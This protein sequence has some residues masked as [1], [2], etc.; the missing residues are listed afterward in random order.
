MAR[1][2]NQTDA[3]STRETVRALQAGQLVLLPTDTVYGLGCLVASARALEAIFQL[4]QRPA[5]KPLPL[6]LDSPERAETLACLDQR[7]RDAAARYW[8]AA[9]TLVLPARPGL[10]GAV[11]REGTVGLRVPALAWLRRVIALCDS[12]L[13]CTS[14]NLSGA[15]ATGAFSELAPEILAGADLAVD[16][17]TLGGTPSAIWDLTRA[18]PRRLR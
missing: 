1:T 3:G 7:R 9:D 8:A 13:A 6:L 10:P 5:D 11:C 14:A 4:K 16:G 17:G 15:P 12:P 2:I 18:A